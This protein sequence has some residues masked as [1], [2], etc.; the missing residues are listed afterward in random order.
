MEASRQHSSNNIYIATELSKLAWIS[1]LQGK[2]HGFNVRREVDGGRQWE[3]G[4]C[5]YASREHLK[6]SVEIVTLHVL[7]V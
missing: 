5:D 7:S 3:R 2:I 1:S 4:E 6:K